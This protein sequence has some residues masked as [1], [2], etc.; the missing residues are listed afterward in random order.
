ML[1]AN[2]TAW[3]YPI[4]AISQNNFRWRNVALLYRR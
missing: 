4:A 1:Y 3:V 2:L